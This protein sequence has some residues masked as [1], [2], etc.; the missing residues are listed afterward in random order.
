MCNNGGAFRVLSDGMSVFV[1]MFFMLLLICVSEL[2]SGL[3]L[4]LLSSKQTGVKLFHSFKLKPFLLFSI[5][6]KYLQVT[7]MQLLRWLL[8]ACLWL[9]CITEV[10]T[11]TFK[12]ALIGPWSCDPIFSRAMPTAAANLALSRLQSDGSLSRGYRYSIKL[13]E[14]DCSLSKGSWTSQITS[15]AV[16]SQTETSKK[17][18]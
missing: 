4:K 1:K 5:D 6:D 13:L 9:L 11:A 17:R 16:H 14:E 12:L 7:R 10:W 15:S 2:W 18:F 3:Y 8:R